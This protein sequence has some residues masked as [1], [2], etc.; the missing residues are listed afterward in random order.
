MMKG[1]L[2]RR[3]F[4]VKKSKAEKE[5]LQAEREKKE[6]EDVIEMQRRELELQEQTAAVILLQKRIRGAG[7][8]KE[9]GSR[10]EKREEDAIEQVQTMMRGLLAR[11]MRDRLRGLESDDAKKAQ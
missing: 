9:F 10:R 8:R 1:V 2:G 11:A 7:A 3:K 5:R 6:A 4:G